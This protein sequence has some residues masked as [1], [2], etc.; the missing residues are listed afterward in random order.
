MSVAHPSDR[1]GHERSHS[2]VSPPSGD[3]PLRDAIL[4]VRAGYL[5]Q[6]KFC[7]IEAL[8]YFRE[9]VRRIDEALSDSDRRGEA[10]ETQSGS[11]VGKSAGPQDIAKPF[12][13]A[14]RS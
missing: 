4:K 9:F 11:T 1:A 7:D 13:G 8:G 12:P 14:P 10:S 6:M 3:H 5:T 2:A